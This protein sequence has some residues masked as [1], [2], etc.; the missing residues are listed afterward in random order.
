MGHLGRYEKLKRIY[1]QLIAHEKRDAGIANSCFS[2]GI[3]VFDN[4]SVN[5]K[6]NEQCIIRIF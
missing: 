5:I 2:S 4:Y 6:R 3:I 1:D